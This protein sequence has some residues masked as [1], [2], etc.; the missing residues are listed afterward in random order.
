M[1]THSRAHTHREKLTAVLQKSKQF[2]EGYLDRPSIHSWEPK[3]SG[4]FIMRR[5]LILGFPLEMLDEFHF[6]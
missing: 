3:A 1:D 5:L 6:I 4:G 2:A